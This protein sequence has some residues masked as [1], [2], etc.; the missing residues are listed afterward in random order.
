MQF[1]GGE[2]KY[3]YQNN[4]EQK[5]N[6]NPQQNKYGFT[7]DL[8]SISTSQKKGAGRPLNW[9]LTLFQAS[10]DALSLNRTIQFHHKQLSKINL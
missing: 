5:Y 6:A 2:I 10:P 8:L 9:W 7:H 3:R 1:S 4:D